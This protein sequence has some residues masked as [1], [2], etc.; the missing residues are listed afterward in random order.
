VSSE[1]KHSLK[2]DNHYRSNSLKYEGKR[3]G[4]GRQIAI[5]NIAA[6]PIK[7]IGIKSNEFDYVDPVVTCRSILSTFPFFNCADGD[8]DV[9]QTGK[10][11]N[12][13]TKVDPFFAEVF[14][15]GFGIGWV[16]PLGDKMW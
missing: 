14:T 7:F 15:E 9:H 4:L 2:R 12:G 16:V 3:I 11:S 10:F 8:A 1:G 5:P 13:E 6:L